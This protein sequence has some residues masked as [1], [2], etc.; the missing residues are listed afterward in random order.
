MCYLHRV[1]TLHHDTTTSSALQDVVVYNLDLDLLE[2]QGH[3]SHVTLHAPSDGASRPV[4]SEA[5]RA[6]HPAGGGRARRQH[7]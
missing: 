1:W 3:V 7:V 2:H 5:P 6:A 4:L